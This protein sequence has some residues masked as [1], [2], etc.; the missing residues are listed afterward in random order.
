LAPKTQTGNASATEL[1]PDKK[2]AL[3]KLL[4]KNEPQHSGIHIS[5]R[6]SDGTA[7]LSFAQQRLWFF[8]QLMPG[9]T[10]YN[11][12]MPL[13]LKFDLHVEALER[14]LN[15]IV[16]RHDVLRTSFISA[17]GKPVQV[18]APKL[19]VPLTVHDLRGN[20]EKDAESQRLTA[21][22]AALPFDI[23]KAPLIRTRLIRL[24]DQDYILLLTMHHIVSDAWSISI[25]FQELNALYQ[26]YLEGK[27]S[28]LPALP[29]QYS[30]FAI[31]QREWLQGKIIE[32][33]LRYWEQQLAGLETCSLPGDRPRPKISSF[34]G[35]AYH[36]PMDGILAQKV[37]KLSTELE[38][39]P[40][41]T[42]LTALK[43]LVH[44]Y[45]G[46]DDIVIGSPTAN[47]NRSEIEPL[48]GFFV[49]SVVMRTN[50]QG[51]LSFVEA[52]ARVRDCALGAY[53]NQDLPF[54][55]LVEQL[56]PE[57]D[58]GRNPL[59][60]IMFQV[61]AAGGNLTVMP[62][63]SNSVFD[64]TLTLW[65]MPDGMMGQF[66]YNTDLFD[67]ATIER[68]AERYRAVLECVL[69]NPGCHI[70]DI[71][72]LSEA[73][74]R[75]LLF[76]WNA[77]ESD[78]PGDSSV[79]QL[80]EEQAYEKP[81]APA[82]VSGEES[83]TYADLN[84]RAN[85]LADYIKGRGAGPGRLVGIS[86]EP[87]LD[88]IVAVLAVLKAGAAYVPLDPAYPVERLSFL[89]QDCKP[90][91]VITREVL[92][93]RL[94][95]LEERAVLL[96]RDA[97]AIASCSAKN[98][99]HGDSENTAYVIYTSGSTG[100]PKG[101]CVSHRS[102][103][104]FIIARQ[105]FYRGP[106]QRFL[107]VSPFSFDSSVA[108]IFS[109]LSSGGALHIA[110]RE[111]IRDPLQLA[112]EIVRAR[113][114]HIL[115]VPSLYLALLNSFDVVGLQL[116]LVMVAGEAC[117]AELVRRHFALLPGVELVNEYGPT[118]ATVWSTAY[119][120]AAG[121]LP[122]DPFIGRP[123]ANTRLYVVDRNYRP[124]PVG[125]YGELWIAGL[126]V[127]RG[128]L[129][130][131]D[132][133]AERFIPNPFEPGG[134][135]LYRTGDLARYRPDGNLEFMGRMDQQV[136]IR[137]FRIELGEIEACL[138]SHPAVAECA[139]FT[140]T[141]GGDT[142][143]AVCAVPRDEFPQGKDDKDVLVFLRRQLPEY[144]APP[145]I[146]WLPELPRNQNGK[147]DRRALTGDLAQAAAREEYVA[148]RTAAETTVALLYAEVLGISPPGVHDNFY[149][150]GGHSLLATQLLSRVNRAFQL[151]LPL[152][153]ML[154]AVTVA[155]LAEVVEQ[156]VLDD[157]AAL[158]DD[159]VFR[160]VGRQA[161]GLIG[162][163][164]HE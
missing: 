139:A 46:Q 59:F 125:V 43:V 44:R 155:T 150:L 29:L 142:H 15:E 61:L 20:P 85:Q 38:A 160:R 124:V 144:M 74:S 102:L 154:E 5:K 108:G 81:V 119:R 12:S 89:L 7:P 9:A 63:R 111:T 163:G 26:A 58:L 37:K 115:T 62:Q 57:R 130:R 90:I 21:E 13:P 106:V 133:T 120:C 162:A 138:A 109:T 92:V 1:S 100:R 145:G 36:L 2:A 30:D 17:D 8:D 98:L 42:Q 126:G 159:E 72:L 14:A 114:T 18:V 39:T 60:Q 116:K 40:F 136:K 161:T 113:I 67:A 77:T 99:V 128:Y 64:L 84:M 127:A 76:E 78:C 55:M 3:A 82:V 25:F 104:H 156:Q 79:L 53:C 134:E 118:E 121:S 6:D 48:I 146:I 41:M 101:V 54:E 31:W 91:L 87:T 151:D 24:D 117:K 129:N 56:Q 11:L 35:A 32:E 140:W 148:P 164:N 49:N 131:P 132:L 105:I 27:P 157:I 80:I 93:P 52:V 4:H 147:L 112:A 73:E 45:T 69:E 50:L 47:R 149:R 95:A 16:R 10:V 137:G 83:L 153:V 86:L 71:D 51:N 135:R 70:G 103:L 143:L 88:M 123:I 68:L 110:P 23:K 33:Q 75:Q 107:L 28:P 97:Q 34:R 122:A 152:R 22:E 96:D 19:Q 65:E 158:S 141:R 94:P 66:E